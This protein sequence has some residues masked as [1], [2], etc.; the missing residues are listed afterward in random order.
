MDQDFSSLNPS[1]RRLSL[2]GLMCLYIKIPSTTGG[3]EG[4]HNYRRLAKHPICTPA[5]TGREEERAP[6]VMGTAFACQASS[7][8]NFIPGRDKAG[9]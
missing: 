1:Q 8:Q 2:I 5:T 4:N 6:T 9:K 3:S 7:Q